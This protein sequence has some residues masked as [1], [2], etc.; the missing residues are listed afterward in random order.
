[1]FFKNYQNM[2]TATEMITTFGGYCHRDVISDGQWF[3]M[4]NMSARK[5]PAITT[6]PNRQVLTKVNGEAVSNVAAMVDMDGLVWLG[7]DGS[8]H[9]G[10]NV[11]PNFYTYTEADRQMVPMGGYLIVFPDKVWANAVKLRMGG[12]MV[13][14]VD[15]GKLEAYWEQGDDEPGETINEPN[16]IWMIPCQSDGEYWKYIPEGYCELEWKSSVGSLVVKDGEID[17]TDGI[18]TGC[19]PYKE[20]HRGNESEAWVYVKDYYGF[21]VSETAP[22]SPADNCLWMKVSDVSPV[23]Q[24][25]FASTRMWSVQ[26]CN[27]RLESG[28]GFGKIEDGDS[29]TLTMPSLLFAEERREHGGSYDAPRVNFDNPYGEN[30]ENISITHAGEEAHTAPDGTETIVRYIAL[31]LANK[32]QY[33]IKLGSYHRQMV[34]TVREAQYNQGS[35]EGYKKSSDEAVWAMTNEELSAELESLNFRQYG[36]RYYGQVATTISREVPDMDY[37][38]ESNNRL[39]GCFYGERDG[40]MLNEIYASKLGDF[41]NWNCFQGLSTDSYAAS[42]GSDGPWTG[43]I[44]MNNYPLFF[45]RNCLEKVYISASGAHQI[46]TTKM[47]GVQ[48]GSWRSMQIVDGVLFYLSDTGVMVYDG[49]LPDNISNDFGNVKYSDGVA[50]KQGYNYYLSVKAQDGSYSLFNLDTTKGVWHR[51]DD[52]RLMQTADRGD[53]LYMLTEDGRLLTPGTL[54]ELDEGELEGDFTWEIV[55]GAIGYQRA[56]QEYLLRLIPRIKLELGGSALV[57]VMFDDNGEWQRVACIEGN[58]TQSMKVPVKPR[59]CDHFRIKLSGIGEATLYTIT[60]EI[61]RGSV[62]T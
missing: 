22:E 36:F 28:R 13:E 3:D 57:H 18:Y 56:E 50:G 4:T 48:P 1:M 17:A 59:R 7:K 44:T 61:E 42:R 21:V 2:A 31:R 41:K 15:Y 24:R 33:P 19:Y 32:I 49:S 9:A 45:K 43:A 26:S 5:Y 38:I 29:V 20:Y 47:P 30:V 11:L 37:V 14:D 51:E 34:N 12:K 35:D 58:G 27:V 55:S 52:T 16:A 8:L 62:E 6:R 40:K 23:M 25:W 39:W 46:A 10:G 60:R 53:V 54:A